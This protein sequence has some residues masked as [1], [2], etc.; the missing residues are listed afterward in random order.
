MIISSPPQKQKEIA[1]CYGNFWTA[2][3][4]CPVIG[5]ARICPALCLYEL[6]MRVIECL[7][8][9]YTLIL[10]LLRLD[11]IHWLLNLY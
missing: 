2:G 1:D 11:D 8:M 3:T 6:H 5:M 9:I 4:F 7:W 10:S